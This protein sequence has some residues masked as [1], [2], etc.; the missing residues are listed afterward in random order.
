[1][2]IAEEALEAARDGADNYQKVAVAAWPIRA[3]IERSAP[4]S[5]EAVTLAVLPLA[6]NIE[7]IGSQAEAL[8]LLFQATLPGRPSTWKPVLN[9][10]LDMPLA[11]FHWRHR[12][13]LRDA[14]SMVHPKD[15]NL[16]NECLLRIAD[17][18]TRRRIETEI[19]RPQIA[20]PRPFFW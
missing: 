18:K 1:M 14:V 12:R 13:A 11:P 4:E 16:V 8:M 9:A 19:A 3:L 20:V 6:S 5:A 10:I 15:P 17:E 7:Y 2:R